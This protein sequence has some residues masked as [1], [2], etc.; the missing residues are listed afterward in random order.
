MMAFYIGTTPD[1]V[2]Q[3]REGFAKIIADIKAKPLP[4]ELLQAGANRL[5]GEYYRDKQSLDARAGVAATDAV[6]GLP[7]DFSKSLI[8][9]AAKLTPADIQAVAQK[10]LDEKN[11][12]NMVSAVLRSN[13]VSVPV[14]TNVL[15]AKRS[16]TAC[17]V[18]V[19]FTPA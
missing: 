9:K 19:M 16:S 6:L 1:R 10:Y 3:A 4:E 8:D 11:L 14:R 2:A 12:Y 15:P 5:L 7:R 18:H 13:R 17:S